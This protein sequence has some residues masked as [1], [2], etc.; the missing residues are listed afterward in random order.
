MNRDDRLELWARF[1][2]GETLSLEEE[3]A[4]AEAFRSDEAL[5]AEMLRDARLDGLLQGL[6]SRSEHPG[7]FVRRVLENL[8]HERDGAR[9]V[10]RTASRVREIR[11]RRSGAV[12]VPEAPSERPGTRRSRSAARRAGRAVGAAAA[13][14]AVLILAVAFQ[15]AR[16]ESRPASVRGGT[17]PAAEARRD[18]RTPPSP[19]DRP[20]GDDPA[21]PA[22]KPAK[23]DAVGPEVR[24][25]DAP[26][27]LPPDGE[28][29]SDRR[30]RL[31]EEMRRRIE[32]QRRR[33]VV[34]PAEK[35]TPEPSPPALP[36]GAASETR[37]SVAVLEAVHG[38]VLVGDGGR[39]SPAGAGQALRAGQ[40]LDVRGPSGAVRIVFADRTRIDV[41]ADT[42]LR[43]IRTEGGKRVVLERGELRAEVVP[44]PGD[45]A[46][47]FATPQADATVLGTTLRI[48]A[49]GLKTRLEVEEGKVRLLRRSDGRALDVSSGHFAVAAAG[50]EL[51]ARR[52]PIQEIVLLPAQARFGGSEWRRVKDPRA[53]GDVA[54]EAPKAWTSALA[55]DALKRGALG[56]AEFSFDADAE[57]EYTVWVRAACAGPRD[58]EHDG[59][60][61]AVPEGRFL[62]RCSFFGPRNLDAYLLTAYAQSETYGW[63]SE[64]ERTS[65]GQLRALSPARIQFSRAGRQILRLYPVEG[66][67]RVDAIWISATQKAWPAA[68]AKL[69]GVD[70]R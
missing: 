43:E 5:R 31:E 49:D 1:L 13:A 63:G 51:A 50:A 3:E 9:F 57:R 11:E 64:R 19:P 22:A 2:A 42:F 52:L 23:V 29:E 25:P 10:E 66:P 6:P 30:R 53:L 62:D 12:P 58:I 68:D 20:P 59:L 60:A 4:L 27:T 33:P 18:P 65:T 36:G 15:V 47:V 54:L 24:P 14:A 39:S 32:D 61:I 56:Y 16:R 67:I 70:P 17:D 7:E 48:V 35:A 40:S 55:A 46:L 44:Q 45:A 37:V 28:S 8:A 69:P 38:S 34:D 21:L 26:R 41:G